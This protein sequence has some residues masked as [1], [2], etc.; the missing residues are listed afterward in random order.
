MGVSA[1]LVKELEKVTGLRI[2]RETKTDPQ[3]GL[4]RTHCSINLDNFS[5]TSLLR[6][7]AALR[8]EDDRLTRHGGSRERCPQCGSERL[9][10]VTMCADCGCTVFQ[11]QDDPE[12]LWEP[13]TS[14]SDDCRDRECHCHS[15]ALLGAR[16]G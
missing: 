15:D 16:R 12:I 13:G 10:T 14:W 5:G 4:P 7:V 8:A 11:A 9:I 1:D 6:N 2:I 3:S